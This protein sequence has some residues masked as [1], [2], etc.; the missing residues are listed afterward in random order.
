MEYLFEPTYLESLSKDLI[1]KLTGCYYTS[2]IVAKQGICSLISQMLKKGYSKNVVTIC[3]PFAGDGR[4]VQWFIQE[5]NRLQGPPVTWQVTLWDINPQGKTMADNRIKLLRSQNFDI[6]YIYTIEDTFELSL[7]YHN[8]FDIIV[9]NPPWEMLK[10]DSNVCRNLSQI[11]QA[12][13]IKLLQKYDAFLKMHYPNSQPHKK[14]AGWGT[15][16][17]RVGLEA[18]HFICCEQ[19]WCLILLPAS[20][21]ADEQ[22]KNIRK[23]IF[24]NNDILSVSYYPAEAKLFNEAD[25]SASILIYRK[26]MMPESQIDLTLFDKNLKIIRKEF[27]TYD[28]LFV[29]KIDFIIPI[30]LGSPCI[31]IIKKIAKRLPTWGVL[32]KQPSEGLWAG[33]ELDE[34]RIHEVLVTDIKGI[35]FVKGNMIGRYELKIPMTQT[36]KK[37]NWVPPFSTTLHKIVWR[38]VSRPSQKRRLIATIVSKEVVAGNSLGVACYK[39]DNLEHLKILLGIINSLCFEFQLRAYLAT[40]HISLSAMRKVCLPSKM[41]YKKFAKILNLV[42]AIM[43]G[44]ENALF[45]IEAVIAKEV[46]QLNETELNGV[47]NSFPLLSVTEKNNILQHFRGLSQKN[48]HSSPTVLVYENSESSN[49]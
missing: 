40:S 2:E 3:D 13:Y 8:Q 12:T 30:S 9:T 44:D 6:E 32:E 27:L 10:P 7:K 16:L 28:N 24:T 48:I 31:Q 33:R 37:E 26:H 11:Q 14:F 23:N 35:K 46:Y 42:N 34:T 38:D 47:L 49:I 20:F 43:Q 22:S 41:D 15:N 36:V 19:G 39:D 1:K 18:S 17:S 25:V 4:L 45:Q 29:D 21:F 5:W